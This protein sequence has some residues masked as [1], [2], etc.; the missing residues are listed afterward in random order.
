[1][2]FSIITPNYNGAAFLERTIKSVVS[3]REDG[4]ELEYILVDGGST[5]DSHAI[6]KRYRSSI[7]CL[8]SEKDHGPANAI[9]KGLA[10]ATGDIV[11]WLNAD[12]QYYPGSLERV[13]EVFAPD[14]ELALCFGK[15]P[16]VDQEN[17]EIRK[18]ITRFKEFF[19][20][21]SSHF[22]IQCINYVSQP[23]L[24]FKREALMKTGNLRE[25]MVAA[26]DYDFLLRLWRQGKAVAIPG[27]PVSAFC[28]HD[29]SISGR[30]FKVQFKEELDVAAADA[31]RF[32]PQTFIH[33][34]VRWGIVCAY[35]MMA[36][37]RSRNM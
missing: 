23:A 8:I 26:W 20:P 24:F 22:V 17:R 36:L 30:N 21:V 13:R 14:K 34:G 5:D 19:F 37:L 3:Q 27:G 25:D 6:I 15:C 29:K 7:D 9:N 32:A 18:A 35:S 28:W 10:V 16:I 1:M 11:A 33:N 12:D 2:R 31:G 4:I